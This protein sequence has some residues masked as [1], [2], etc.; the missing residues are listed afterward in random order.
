MLHGDGLEGLGART[1]ELDF[2]LLIAGFVGAGVLGIAL[3]LALP[4]DL[5]VFLVGRFVIGSVLVIRIGLD[6][7]RGI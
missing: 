2:A 5:R 1:A 6:F 4:A 7:L 3:A